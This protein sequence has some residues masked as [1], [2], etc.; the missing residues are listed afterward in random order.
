MSFCTQ[1]HAFGSDPEAYS[2]CAGSESLNPT[3]YDSAIHLCLSECVWGSSTWK[4][5]ASSPSAPQTS[6]I[7]AT[8]S[9]LAS[10]SQTLLARLPS[11]WN[12]WPH[13][14][15]CNWNVSAPW[16][17]TGSVFWSGCTCEWTFQNAGVGQGFH[18]LV[19]FWV[20]QLIKWP[21]FHIVTCSHPKRPW[22]LRTINAE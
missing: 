1:A 5:S 22:I 8:P 11:T 14:N 13:R 9:H 7:S 16:P 17:D 21:C 19:H 3:V 20:F 18:P 4:W 6:H 2:C 12:R 15:S 10:I